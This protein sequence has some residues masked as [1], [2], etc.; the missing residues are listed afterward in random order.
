MLLPSGALR[1]AILIVE[2]YVPLAG[3]VGVAQ[4]QFSELLPIVI[5]GFD[6]APKT[7]LAPVADR[8]AYTNHV[9][10]LE[11]KWCVGLLGRLTLA[12]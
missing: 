6:R 3:D 4:E 7:T 10:M 11:H 2:V 9:N 5:G 1:V 12:L 8:A